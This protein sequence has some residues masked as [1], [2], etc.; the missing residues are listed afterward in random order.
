MALASLATESRSQRYR[1][2]GAASPDPA[3]ALDNEMNPHRRQSAP[4]TPPGHAQAVAS[5]TTYTTGN[6]IDQALKQWGHGTAHI[7]TDS[8]NRPRTLTVCGLSNLR[9][10]CANCLPMDGSPLSFHI[11][12]WSDP[13]ASRTAC[14]SCGAELQIDQWAHWDDGT[15]P[16]SQVVIAAAAQGRVAAQQ[17]L[18]DCAPDRARDL[19]R[20][21]IDSENALPSHDQT[22]ICVEETA[23]ERYWVPQIL[24]SDEP[25]QCEVI[26]AAPVQGTELIV[27][28]SDSSSDVGWELDWDGYV[29]VNSVGTVDL[30]A[31]TLAVIALDP[32]ELRNIV[33]DV[34]RHDEERQWAGRSTND[35]TIHHAELRKLRQLW[36]ERLAA[37][38]DTPPVVPA[39]LCDHA[40][41]IQLRDC[42][43]AIPTNRDTD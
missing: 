1:Q 13:V 31:F 39:W 22:G 29:Q 15:V 8:E 37:G 27:A 2:A 16:A 12:Q 21:L 41:L 36:S 25:R 3:R 11:P 20:E 40:A 26:W 28:P 42:A 30:T 38:R 33:R 23:A 10:C 18:I 5:A 4:Q 19:Y 9:A 17:L 24:V 6:Q 35:P 43:Q 34:K 14:A 32:D 7:T